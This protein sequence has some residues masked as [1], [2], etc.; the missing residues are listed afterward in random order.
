MKLYHASASPNSRR[1]RI[2]IAEMGLRIDLV[3]V[4][5]GTKEQFSDAYRAINSRVVVPT[6]VLDDGTAI[7]EV[8][9]IMRYLD[10]AYPDGPLL[11][12]TPKDKGV[13]TMWERR[14]EL[15]GFTPVMEGVRNAAERLK[16]RAISGPH[17]YEQ[18]PG[19]V[20][21]SR[22]RVANFYSDFEARLKEAEFVAGNQFSA[23][24]ITMLVT[25]DFATRA[26]EMPIPD[27]SVALKS[28]YGVTSTR[29]SAAA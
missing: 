20:E 24:D 25:V 5:L 23:A 29:P 1:V 8:P 19:L 22:R 27:G 26:F 15:E 2:F 16:G 21:R 6:L 11:G 13:I 10:E 14:V 3:P 9:A 18:I 17:D 28:W 7:G 4:D 12:S